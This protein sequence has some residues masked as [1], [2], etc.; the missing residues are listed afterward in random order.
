M[1]NHW[2]PPR[3]NMVVTRTPLR[4]SFAGGG[5]DLAAFY[6]RD[7]GAVLSTAITQY[8]YVTVKR[9]GQI[10]NE[11]I[12]LNY[13][14]SEQVQ[15]IEEIENNIARE[16]LRFVAIEPP[17]YISTVGDLP[18]ST[19][20]GGS[21]SFAVGLLNA[22]HAYQGERVSAG[23]LAEEAS[24]IEIEVLKEPIGKQDQ[25]A[26]AFGGLNFFCFK[27]GGAVTVEPQRLVNGT[28]GKLFDHIL[29]FWTGHQRDSSSVLAEQK[30]KTP[31]KLESLFKI[32]GHAQQLQELLGTGGCDLRV[33]GG[34]LDE[35]WQQ[36]RR[37]ASTITNSQIDT[38]YQRA[39]DA[40]AW[41]G[42][43]CG[44]GGG[45]F[46]L[47]VVPPERQNAVR[48]S[49]SDLQEV[50]VGPEAHGSQILFVE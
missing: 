28:L 3:P 31:E 50:P 33:F 36:K 39:S 8:I 49:L 16:C 30:A 46:L 29:M 14:K 48:Q 44:A 27:P 2:R 21:S 25:Y 12:R 41:G 13:S 35:S 18:A 23:Q 11:R 24:Y 7:Y 43:L 19:G 42:K 1:A 40:G 26:A 32:R 34:I 20:L 9:H 22:L 37:L 38:W 4:V 45:G 5:T 17:I 10:F 47:F 15:E 6:E